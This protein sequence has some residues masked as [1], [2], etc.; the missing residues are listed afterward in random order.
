MRRLIQVIMVAAVMAVI[1]GIT[2]LSAFAQD[3]T[4]ET[5]SEPGQSY[6]GPVVQGWNSVTGEYGP[7]Q[8]CIGPN[9]DL[10]VQ[11]S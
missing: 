2:A 6:C 5:F 1:M 3:A 7:V 10:Y 11:Y 9:G 8:Y 4:D